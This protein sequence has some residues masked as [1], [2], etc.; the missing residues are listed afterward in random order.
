MPMHN[1]SKAVKITK[2]KAASATST[3]QVDADTLD[4]Q[5][6]EG[7]VFQTVIGTAN[8]GNYVKVGQGAASDGSDKADLAGSKVTISTDG[9][10]AFVDVFRPTK[11]YLTASVVR[12]ATT[13]V[14]E[15]YALQYRG[16]QQA[17]NNIVA[18]K[19]TGKLLVSPAEGTA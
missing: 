14:G 3:A 1:L 15:V 10:I 7:V 8:T 2:V 4:M 11:R 16:A 9:M 5:G 13:T 6:Y 17:E 12:G 19:S 18:N